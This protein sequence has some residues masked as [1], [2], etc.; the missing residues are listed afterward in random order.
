MHLYIFKR[1]IS[2]EEFIS[3]QTF[4]YCQVQR[5][6]SSAIKKP[7]GMIL[8]YIQQEGFSKFHF[9]VSLWWWS[10][11]SISSWLRASHVDSDYA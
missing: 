1:Q 11:F 10:G 7:C 8:Q 2:T 4:N 9:S 3:T 6:V 5:I